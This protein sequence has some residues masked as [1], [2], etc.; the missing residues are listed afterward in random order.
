MFRKLRT[1]KMNSFMTDLLALLL[2]MEDTDSVECLFDCYNYSLAS[3]LD[4]H[5]SFQN[6]IFTIRPGILGIRKKIGKSRRP[7]RKLE[8]QDG[9]AR[10]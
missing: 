6:K 3:V 10:V 7:V 1:I 2:F 5:G 9:R 4:K 8:R